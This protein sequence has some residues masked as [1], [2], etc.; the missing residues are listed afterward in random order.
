MPPIAIARAPYMT[1]NS[2]FARTL[3]GS[4]ETESTSAEASQERREEGNIAREGNT[5]YVLV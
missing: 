5:F 3:V 2:G 1:G 4:A